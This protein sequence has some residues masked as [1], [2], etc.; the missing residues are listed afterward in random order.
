MKARRYLLSVATAQLY[1]FLAVQFVALVPDKVSGGRSGVVVE[2]VKPQSEAERAGLQKSDVILSWTERDQHRDVLSP[3]DLEWIE[4]AAG[5]HSTVRFHGLRNGRKQTWVLFKSPWNFTCIPKQTDFASLHSKVDELARNKRFDEMVR[6]YDAIAD[7]RSLTPDVRLW[8]LIDG[9][10]SFASA[11]Q[12]TTADQ[13][14]QRASQASSQASLTA[15]SRLFEVWASFL[16]NQ[17]EFDRAAEVLKRALE[18]NM[19]L[20]PAGLACAMDLHGLARLSWQKADS[21]KALQ[22]VQRELEIRS[23]IDYGTISCAQSLN[24]A[25][26]FEQDLG[27]LQAAEQYHQAALGILQRVDPHGIES[28]KTYSYLGAIMYRRGDLASAEKY[29]LEAIRLST[30]V[31]P[32]RYQIS[33]TWSNLG[34][35]AQSRG[36]L[37]RAQRYYTRALEMQRSAGKNEDCAITLNNLAMLAL[38]QS[39]FPRAEG[40][41]Q[42]ALSLQRRLLPGSTYLAQTLDTAGSLS[43]AQGRLLEAE[44]IY[45]EAIAIMDKVSPNSLMS[46]NVKAGLCQVLID[47]G[48][49]AKAEPY[50]DAAAALRGLFAPNSGPYAE[51]LASLAKIRRLQKDST[52]A[53]NYYR[54]ALDVLDR[55]V[56]LLGG[57]EHELQFR[58]KYVEYYGDYID[59]LVQAGDYASALEVLERMRARTFLEML[60]EAQVNIRAADPGLMAKR[61]KLLGLLTGLSDQRIRTLASTNGNSNVAVLDERIDSTMEQLNRIDYEIGRLHPQTMA[62]THPRLMRTNEMQKLLDDQTVVLSYLISE[63]CSYVFTVTSTSLDVYRLP[64]RDAISKAGKRLYQLWT[65]RPEL[66]SAQTQRSLE[67]EA[68]RNAADF[69]RMVLEQPLQTILLKKRVVVVADEILQYIPFAALPLPSRGNILLTTHEVVNLPSISV[70]SALREQN[71]AKN[72]EEIAKSALVFADPVFTA[73]DPRVHHTDQQL[74]ESRPAGSGISAYRDFGPNGL[75]RLR[76]SRMEADYIA[77]VEGGAREAIDFN[78][79]RSL[80]TSPETTRYRIVHFATHGFVD[81]THPELSALVLSLVDPEGKPRP[82]ILSLQDIYGLKLKCDLAVLSGCQTALGAEI[83]GEGLVGLTRGFMYAGAKR[84]VSSL[85]SV[86]DAG[87]AKLMRYFY[88]S[89][90]RNP[91]LSPAAALRAAQFQLSQNPRWHLPYYW[92]AFTIQGDWQTPPLQRRNSPRD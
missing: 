34:A 75:S 18:I 42:E 81:S 74:A 85:W 24:Y 30:E 32:H 43:R 15:H 6:T 69:A 67:Q 1:S 48:N 68:N 59:L 4:S 2:D 47:R 58:S 73:N 3:S 54:Q 87:T 46:A 37:E 71:A 25:G 82:G 57:R 49:L 8:T 16:E 27:D 51:S 66:P 26:V 88:L 44:G 56:T 62:L 14:F 89:M 10:K 61:E 19:K 20:A 17:R 45:H 29:Y 9:A 64:D 28:G 11:H 77:S 41:V 21:T 50:C 23:R 78:A 76:Y 55:Q 7:V 36:D 22:Y 5:T 52:Q 79:N 60:Q 31:D 83:K 70:L 80:A 91:G 13:F 40:F 72:S 92:A 38:E 33:Y 63:G 12:V 84:V 90:T 53:K 86:D 39:D 35:V 65:T